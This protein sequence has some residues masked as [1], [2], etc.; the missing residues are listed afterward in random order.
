VLRMACRTFS[1]PTFPDADVPVAGA[2]C[3]QAAP[4]LNTQAAARAAV[5]I[6][7]ILKFTFFSL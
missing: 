2:P 5:R 3:A 6:D 4:A 1:T 7:A